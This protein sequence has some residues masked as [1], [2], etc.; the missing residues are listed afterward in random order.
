M[1]V[2]ILSHEY[3]PVTGGAG[4]AL[5]GFLQ[6]TEALRDEFD[7]DFTVVVPS[8]D[9]CNGIQY[10]FPRV[11]QIV[12]GVGKTMDHRTRTRAAWR[13]LRQVRRLRIDADLWHIWGAMPNVY[14]ARK[15]F[16][17]TLHGSDVP[18]RNP[19]RNRLW[20]IVGRSYRRRWRKAAAITAVTGE[21]T[22]LASQFV[23]GQAI[24]HIPNGIVLPEIPATRPRCHRP[25]RLLAVTRIAPLK[26]IPIL[27]Q[28]GNLLG[29]EAVLRVVGDGPDFHACSYSPGVQW[30]GWQEDLEPHYRWA[31]IF[32]NVTQATGPSMTMMEAKSYGLPIVAVPFPNYDLVR[33]LYPSA[34]DPYSLI[35]AVHYVDEHYELACHEASAGREEL[36]WSVRGR[37]YCDLYRSILGDTDESSL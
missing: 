12:L 34:A 27:Q 1:H 2:L 4:T 26:N 21:L 6:G 20:Q 9:L 19:G 3:P 31:D 23:Q 8:D 28:L 29:S 37:P 17:L 33:G 36:S 13:W 10:P 35:R 30:A 18:G 5:R 22:V 32:I 15:P 11:T 24:M 14:A 25:I 7:V 16:I